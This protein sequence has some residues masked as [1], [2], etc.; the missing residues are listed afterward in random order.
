[1]P[2]GK[3]FS[4]ESSFLLERVQP[5]DGTGEDDPQEDVEGEAHLDEVLEFVTAGIVDVGIGLVADGGGEAGAGA[6]H[7]GQD[8][9][10]GVGVKLQ[11]H[12]IGQRPHDGGH[13]VVGDHFRHDGADQVQAGDGHQAPHGPYVVHH[14]EGDGLG[15]P[16]FAHGV[17]HAEHAQN[18]EDDAPVHR[19]V[20]FLGF[21]AA[22]DDDDQGADERQVEGV[23]A[24]EEFEEVPVLFKGTQQANEDEQPHGEDG[25]AL[26]AAV[27]RIRGALAQGDDALLGQDAVHAFLRPFQ[28]QGVP[29]GQLG[30]RPHVRDV[31]ALPVDGEHEDVEPLAQF[32]LGQGKSG[33]FRVVGDHAFHDLHV[34]LFQGFQAAAVVPAQVYAF[35]LPD[36]VDFPGVAQ[37]EDAVAF[38]QVDVL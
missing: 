23:E 8:E 21:D 1:M 29:G 6:E 38:F 13:G 20:C 28:Q 25:P 37:E 31:P 24:G 11:G 16:G 19:L 27:V 34:A 7:D 2:A 18:Q 17:P 5:A 3:P 15:E 22:G 9:G 30:V 36:L 12:F 14:A 33:E 10:D 32:E 35:G 4:V 26:L